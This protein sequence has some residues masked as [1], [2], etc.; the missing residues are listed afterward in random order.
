MKRVTILFVLAF[1]SSCLESLLYAQAISLEGSSFIYRGIMQ[2]RLDF[3]SSD[4]C[5]F[6]QVDYSQGRC[7]TQRVAYSVRGSVVSLSSA[8]STEHDGMNGRTGSRFIPC[9][10]SPFIY[11]AGRPLTFFPI[12]GKKYKKASPSSKETIIK[13][14]DSFSFPIKLTILSPLH[15]IATSDQNN[16]LYF[17]NEQDPSSSAPMRATWCDHDRWRLS[18][19]YESKYYTWRDAWFCREAYSPTIRMASL[20]GKCYEYRGEVAESLLFIDDSTSMYLQCFDDSIELSV[21][22]KYLLR[23]DGYLILQRNDKDFY[24]LTNRQRVSCAVDEDILHGVVNCITS[25]TL[26]LAGD[27]LVYSKI[28]MTD[29]CSVKQQTPMYM[30][31]QNSTL[32]TKAF[33]SK[34]AKVSSRKIGAFFQRYFT[35][36]NFP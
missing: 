9:V 21:C 4:S 6:Q 31:K 19:A 28:Y 35:P 11:V 8:K 17:E 36:I 24:G 16:R 5:D 1:L 25:D 15:L 34:D 20:K 7:F 32:V 18:K 12:G 2:Y 27:F 30:Q 22:C 14:L 23:P 29:S 13:G 33:V 3:I 10:V 26:L